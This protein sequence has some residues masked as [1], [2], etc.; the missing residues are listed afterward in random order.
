VAGGKLRVLFA[1]SMTQRKGLADLFAAMKLLR[2]RD[3]ELVV[4][5]MPV[6]PM[7]FYRRQYGGF[8]YESPRP[9]QD[10]LDLMRTC[11]VLALPSIVE[12]RALVQQ[13]AMSQGLPI[14]ITPNTGG[15]DLVVEGETGYVV[16]IRAPEV[17]AARI[18]ALAED[19][20]LARMMG[21]NAQRMSARYSWERY[22]DTIL[23]LLPE[24]AGS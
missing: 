15:E 21:E 23:T 12:G 9:R 1:G 11:D 4:M 22:A 10:V 7:R 3:V 6:A 17:I 16:P 24:E 2:R 18:D 20:D 19:R 13:E 8:T 5:G 14:I